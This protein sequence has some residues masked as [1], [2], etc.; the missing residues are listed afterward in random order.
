MYGDLDDAG[1]P[2]P[3]LDDEEAEREDRLLAGFDLDLGGGPS[4]DADA[5]PL[6]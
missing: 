6:Y 2:I 4:F 5:A 1:T 3:A